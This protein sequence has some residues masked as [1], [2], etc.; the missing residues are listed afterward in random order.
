[1]PSAF[2]TS[3][4]L[5]GL[6]NA[7][8]YSGV[9]SAVWQHKY[10]SEKSMCVHYEEKLSSFT[11]WVCQV[12]TYTQFF[13]KLFT[14]W[15]GS[16]IVVSYTQTLNYYLMYK[17]KGYTEPMQSKTKAVLHWNLFCLFVTSGS[18]FV[19][20]KKRKREETFYSLFIHYNYN[21]YFHYFDFILKIHQN[22]L[23]FS[24]KNN[25]FNFT[26]LHFPCFICVVLYLP[27]KLLFG[28]KQLWEMHS[29]LVNST[30]VNLKN[31]SLP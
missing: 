25:D 29:T 26:I 28:E 24:L 9:P 7:S 14:L 13:D 5:S 21:F 1:M 4:E 31:G 27:P 16:Y 18:V 11:L 19:Q 3:L 12:D 10:D 2:Q 6:W 8:G 17:L 20:Q 22:T 15:D 23:I 30:L